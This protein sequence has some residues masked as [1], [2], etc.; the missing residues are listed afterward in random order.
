MAM[1]LSKVLDL[2]EFF[3]EANQLKP[4]DVANLDLIA[5]GNLRSR[6]VV[7]K[8][9]TWPLSVQPEQH[10]FVVLEGTLSFDI[11]PAHE[12]E[13]DLTKVEHH[14]LSAGQAIVIPPNLAHGG[15]VVRGP[16]MACEVTH[17][18]AL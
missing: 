7:S 3:S 4:N 9:G 17:F 6:I 12:G 10:I 1:P 8:E 18:M 14:E 2:K 11:A 5:E 15:S 13:P 16:A